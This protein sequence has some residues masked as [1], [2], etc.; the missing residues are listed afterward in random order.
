M[1]KNFCFNI[2]LRFIFLSLFNNY[3]MTNTYSDKYRPRKKHIQ[4]LLVNRIAD[5]NSDVLTLFGHEPIS[6]IDMFK[7]VVCKNKII[8]YE[9]DAKTYVNQLQQLQICD[10]NFIAYKDDIFNTSHITRCID[11]DI[12]SFLSSNRENIIE[13]F[14][15]Q[16]SLYLSERKVFWLTLSL[17]GHKIE[18]RNIFVCSFLSE[19]LKC[20]VYIH[21]VQDMF[22][23][24]DGRKYKY[25]NC[26]IATSNM[27]YLVEVNTYADSSNESKGEPMLNIFIESYF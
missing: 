23:E 4:T 22:F 26:R 13:L 11:L 6:V 2:P 3:G 15:K 24:Q 16:Q 19:L 10:A 7:E 8:S 1:L 5:L 14:N 12:M 21:H 27:K 20:D 9:I 25:K 17:R 18:E